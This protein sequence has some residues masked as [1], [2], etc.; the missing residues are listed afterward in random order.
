MPLQTARC[1]HRS[2]SASS[3]RATAGAWVP[4]SYISPGKWSPQRGAGA[5]PV[6]I[7]RS[8][9]EAAHHD[10]LLNLHADSPPSFSRFQRLIEIVGVEDAER[11][12]GRTRFRFYRDRGY[13]ILHHDLANAV[14]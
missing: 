11:Q 6:L 14:S 5:T 9:G 8:D 13:E 3:G 12:S 2:A 4:A 7:A 10:V 1:G